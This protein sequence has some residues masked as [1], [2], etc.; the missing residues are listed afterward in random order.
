ME[1]ELTASIDVGDLQFS[2]NLS[3]RLRQLMG[4]KRV[5]IAE[6]CLIGVVSG[7]AAVFSQTGYRLVNPVAYG[8]SGSCLVSITG[9]GH[10]G[11]LGSGVG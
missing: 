9:H 8:S 5:A 10:V 7:L 1:W 6:A 4:H 11:G 3:R 2:M